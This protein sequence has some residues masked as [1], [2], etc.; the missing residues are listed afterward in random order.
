MKTLVYLVGV[1]GSG[2]S[3][4]SERVFDGVPGR[5]E[6]RPFAHIMRPTCVELGARRDAF[7][8]TDALSMGVQPKVV[9]FMLD[10]D[11]AVFFGEGDRLANIKF[12][13]AVLAAGIHL[14]P[15][16]IHVPE[17]VAAARRAERDSH[18]NVSWIKGRITKVQRVWR[19]YGSLGRVVD[20]TRPVEEV[21]ADVSAILGTCLPR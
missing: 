7:S 2:K 8:G 3:T 11:A 1:P 9:P 17:R 14:I 4:T 5:S 6:S 15:A 19:A 21:A 20:A 13:D 16:L 12:F 18:Q 10:S